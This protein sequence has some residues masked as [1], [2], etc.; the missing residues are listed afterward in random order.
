[1]KTTVIL[2]FPGVGKTYFKQNNKDLK[3]LDSDISK[4]SHKINK[5]TKQKV[6]NKKFPKNYVDY[7][8]KEYQKDQWD[9]ILVSTHQDVRYKNRGDA[10]KIKQI[11]WVN[12]ISFEQMVKGMLKSQLNKRNINDLIF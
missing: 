1:M 7:I 8:K 10:T 12:D 2:A 5:K 3:I 11:G 9:Y 4:Y 6:K